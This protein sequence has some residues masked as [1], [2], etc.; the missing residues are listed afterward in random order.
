MSGSGGDD[1]FFSSEILLLVGALVVFV[2][3]FQAGVVAS[4]GQWLGQMMGNGI[5][6]P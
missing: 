4:F 1:S 6:V 5:P 2:V 3:L